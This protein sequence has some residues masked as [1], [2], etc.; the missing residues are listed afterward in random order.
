M[1]FILELLEKCTRENWCYKI[2]CTTCGSYEM[3]RFL[4]EKASEGLNLERL[5][6]LGD[7]SDP[8]I[9]KSTISRQGLRSIPEIHRSLMIAEICHEL[10]AIDEGFFFEWKN[11]SVHNQIYKIY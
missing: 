4:I 5:G 1:N 3:P 6:L 9:T 2:G 8:I 7:L 10:N 11:I